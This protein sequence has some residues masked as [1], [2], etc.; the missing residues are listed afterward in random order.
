MGSRSKHPLFWF[1]GGALL[2]TLL[3]LLFGTEKGKQTRQ[4]F[5]DWLRKL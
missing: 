1:A 4:Q 2:A 5:S 3:T